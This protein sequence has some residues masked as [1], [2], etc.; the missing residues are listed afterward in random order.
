MTVPV[1]LATRTIAAM[2]SAK[3]AN[4]CA[5]GLGDEDDRCNGRCWFW[6]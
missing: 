2:D 1:A 3:G 6:R 5:S 4:D